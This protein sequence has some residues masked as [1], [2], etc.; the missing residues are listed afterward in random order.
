MEALKHVEGVAT[1][2]EVNV[3]ELG[4][5]AAMASLQKDVLQMKIDIATLRLT[6]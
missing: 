1:K 6:R 5:D 4:I 2:D 3:S